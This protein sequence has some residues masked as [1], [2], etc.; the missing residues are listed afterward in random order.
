MALLF[1]VVPSWLAQCNLQQDAAPCWW[2]QV[3]RGAVDGKLGPQLSAKQLHAGLE[4]DKPTNASA[5][6]FD[7]ESC[8]AA[9]GWTSAAQACEGETR[10]WRRA[11]D[12]LLRLGVNPHR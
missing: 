12:L 3:V 11:C 6:L 4:S 7:T 2:A 5:R 1:I 10:T 9:H 8:T